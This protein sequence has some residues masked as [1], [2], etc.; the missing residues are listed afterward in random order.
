M[1]FFLVKSAIFSPIYFACHR[2]R[3]YL[4][5]TTELYRLVVWAIK[6]KLQVLRGIQLLRNG[7]AMG[8]GGNG[9]AQISVMKMHCMGQCYVGGGCQI[10]RK[11]V[12]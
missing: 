5:H 1:I 10:C 7:K 3:M 12:T 8:G 2:R 6:M 9:S 4:L 11:S